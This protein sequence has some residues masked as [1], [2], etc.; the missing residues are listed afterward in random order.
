MAWYQIIY[1]CGHEDT[2]QLYGKCADRE[3]YIAWAREN[4][5]C[6]KCREA[7]RQARNQ[8]AAQRNAAAGMCALRG[9]RKQVG[10]AES[11]RDGYAAAVRAGETN[12][13]RPLAAI[14]AVACAL[15]DPG[16]GAHIKNAY[17]SYRD[18]LIEA[19]EDPSPASEVVSRTVADTVLEGIGREASASR[20]IDARGSL[21]K[22]VAFRHVD[23]QALAEL[24]LRELRDAAAGREAAG[25]ANDA[26]GD[27]GAARDH[28]P[29]AGPADAL[30][31]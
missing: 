9:S 17:T 31:G 27:G 7:K 24:L 6:P 20:W 3:S 29:S 30:R 2:K 28:E 15:R 4:L 14:D 1:K 19:G 5:V 13:A 22:N 11:I 26:E 8:L 25:Q 10:W 12:L 16:M 23:V 21:T 18:A